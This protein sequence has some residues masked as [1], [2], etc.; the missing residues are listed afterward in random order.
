MLTNRL[1]SSPGLRRLAWRAGRRLYSAARGEE[2]ANDIGGNGEAYVQACVLRAMP[3]DAPAAIVDIGANQGDWTATLLAQLPPERRISG[4]LRLELFEPV[5]AT[6]ASLRGRLA[7]IDPAGI[8]NVTCAA[9][10]DAPGAARMAVM[11]ATGGTNSL[12]FD[13]DDA[14]EALEFV[15]VEK[16]TLTQFCDARGIA[17]LHLA[18][19]D[20]EG[21]DLNVLRGA[22]DLLAAGRIDVFQFEYNHRW[23]Q[24]RSFLKDVFD[25]VDG[26]PYKVARIQPG[27]IEVFE[28]WHPELDRFFQSNYLLVREPALGWFNARRGRFDDANTY[29]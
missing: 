11:S 17:R 13:S 10:S 23:I 22:R 18:K 20:T 3:A 1:M 12:H 2:Q 9:V 15:E 14:R 25:L 6:A 28:A 27:G 24:A 26:M 29:A 8:A 5:P 7:K 19:C 4:L 21:H 16:L